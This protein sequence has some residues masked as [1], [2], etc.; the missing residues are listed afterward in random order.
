MDAM[1]RA[2]IIFATQTFAQFYMVHCVTAHAYVG[3]PRFNHDTVNWI[4]TA[5]SIG[6]W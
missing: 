5:L 2:P 4:M 1:P 6:T 3:N